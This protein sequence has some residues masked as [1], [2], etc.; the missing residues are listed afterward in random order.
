MI[1][2]IQRYFVFF[3]IVI[4]RTLFLFSKAQFNFGWRGK[5]ANARVLVILYVHAV[6]FQ[7]LGG[8]P[9]GIVT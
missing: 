9:G 7:T 4:I 3:F 5:H 6:S 8:I 1:T 2:W